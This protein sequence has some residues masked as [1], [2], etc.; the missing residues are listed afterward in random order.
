[1]EKATGR[2]PCLDDKEA[3]ALLWDRIA[4]LQ[5]TVFKT[6]GR[7]GTGGV[8]FTYSVRKDKNGSWCGEMF[9]STKEK[10]ITR[11]TVM[12]AYQKAAELG[13]VVSGPKKLGTFGAS[14]LY[15]IFIRLGLIKN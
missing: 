12:R 7:N 2:Q 3:E 5:G 13:G 15:S 11:A 1:M 14:Y 10:S 6:S 4:S 8:E 9:I